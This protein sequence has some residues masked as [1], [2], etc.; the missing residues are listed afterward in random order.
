MKILIVDDEKLARVRLRELIQKIGGHN[1]VGEAIN[2]SDAIEK[3]MKYAPDV[4]LMDIRMPVMDGLEAS[5]HLASMESPPSVIFTTAYD[6]HA[7]EAFEVNAVDYL[8]KPIRKERLAMAL[9][10][11]HSLTLNQLREVNRAQEEPSSRSHISV[12][13]RGRINLIPVQDIIYFQADAKYVTVRTAT[14]QHLIEDSLVSLEEEFEEMF[15]RIHRNALAATAYIRGI[16]KHPSGRWQVLFQ[17]IDD[18]LDVSRRHTA[19][20]RRW[21]K[22]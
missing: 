8:L 9:D 7:L 13:L 6:E 17:H 18:R 16:E 22:R 15:L 20:V 14:E 3:T 12:H 4:L 11:V 5:M 10:K 2:G 19:G 21:V 1:I